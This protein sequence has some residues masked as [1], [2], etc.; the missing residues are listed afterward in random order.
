[1]QIL[2]CSP[3][4]DIYNSIINEVFH[5]KLG[6]YHGTKYKSRTIDPPVTDVPLSPTDTI[7]NITINSNINGIFCIK[8]GIYH[9]SK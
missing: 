5:I 3:Q 6:M 9:G 1:M 2:F 7:A 8:L 4:C